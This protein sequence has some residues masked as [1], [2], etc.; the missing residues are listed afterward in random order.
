MVAY[1]AIMA[2]QDMCESVETILQ[3]LARHINGLGEESRMTRRR[4]IEGINK[5]LFQRKPGLEKGLLQGVLKELI[6]PIL[7]LSSD[8]V[9][10]CR[11]LSISLLLSALEGCLEPIEF[12]S[13]VIP[14]LVQRIGQQDIV[15]Q[16]EEIRL[17]L[18]KL[19]KYLIEVSSKR[20]G[21]YVDDCVKILQRTIIDPY[22]EVKKES[23]NCACVLAKTVPEQFH[24]QSESLIKP[25]L[26]T[27]SHQ[28][29]RVRV[30]AVN[31]I[32]TKY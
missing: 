14:F 21:A 30:T 18:V 22:P 29:S 11:E 26:Q 15:E 31:A 13:Y 1:Q 16:S 24:M 6:K 17:Q 7:K 20:I 28:H 32:G 23:C 10:K 9:E 5:E 2:E 3:R 8:T 4:A 12:L 25:L 19:L 27:L